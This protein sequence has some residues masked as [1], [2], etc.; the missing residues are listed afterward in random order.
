METSRGQHVNWNS[1]RSEEGHFNC[2]I[3]TSN[4]VSNVALAPTPNTPEPLYQ[5]L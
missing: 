1:L 2:D 3:F 5:G 4:L